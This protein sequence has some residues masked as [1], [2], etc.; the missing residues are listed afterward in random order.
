MMRI[1]V[2]SGSSFVRTTAL[3]LTVAQISIGVPAIASSEAQQ[4]TKSVESPSVSTPKDVTPNR[5]VPNVAPLSTTL[6]LPAYPTDAELSHARIFAEPL[7]PMPRPTSPQENA[8]LARAILI[9]RDAHRSE[10]V[11]PLLDFLARFPQSAWRPSLLANLGTIY[12]SNGYLARALNAWNLAWDASKVETE[13]HAHAVADFALGELLDLSAKVGKA[14]AVAQRLQEIEKRPVSGPATQRIGVAREAL[15][16]F[17][18]HHDQAVASGPA[19]L[20]GI[21]AYTAYQQHTTRGPNAVLQQYHTMPSGTSLRDLKG[22][23]QQVGLQWQMVFRPAGAELPIPSVV[24]W[25]VDHYSAIVKKDNNRYLLLDPILGG[26][27]WVSREMLDDETSGYFLAPAAAID[28]SWRRV[29]DQ[30]AANVIGH[31]APGAPDDTDPG[32]TDDDPSCGM[33]V[34]SMQMMQAS[35]RIRDTPVQCHAPIGPATRFQATYNQRSSGE[36][37]TFYYG[38]VGPKWT[39]DW[40]SWV[41][42]DPTALD[43]EADVYL[44]GG[45]REHFTDGVVHDTTPYPAH[46]RTRAVL[47]KV[48]SDPVRY[49]RRLRDGGVEVFAQSDGTITSGRRVFLTDIIDPQGL[50]LHLT[51]DSSLRLVAVTDAIG[52]VTTLSYELAS[53]P[54]K[55]TKVT[56]PF[57]RFATLTYN[58]GGQLA[59][60]TDVISLTSRFVYGPYDFVA[61]MTTPYGTT[62]F[63]HET[64]QSQ[65]DS[66][67]FLQATDPVGGTERVEFRYSTSQIAATAAAAEVPTGFSAYNHDLDHFN[68]VYWDKRAMS[69]YPGDV[70]KATITHWRQFSYYSYVPFFYWHGFSTS[71]LSS[72]KRPL[73]NRVWYAYPDDDSTGTAVGT[74]IQPTKVARVLD[75][76]SSQIWQATYND[77]GYPTTVADPVGRQTTLSYASNNIDVA[78]VRQTSSGLNDL[79]ASFTSYTSQHRPQT[80]VDAAGETWT[81]TYNSFG[82]LLTSTNPKSETTTRSYDANGYLLSIVGPVAG[83]TT[84]YAYDAYGRTHTVTESDGYVITAAYDALDRLTQITYPDATSDLTVYDRLDVTQRVDRAGRITRYFHDPL[85]R[86]AT[87]RDPLGR[88]VTQQWCACGSLDKL[89]DGNGH[90][91]SWERDIENRVTREVRADGVTATQYTYEATTSRLATVTDPKGQVATYTYAADDRVTQVAYTNAEHS[92][93]SVSFTY[94]A[95]YPRIATMTDGTGLTTYSYKSVG[96]L[97]GTQLASVDGPLGNDTITYD[98][99][100]LGRAIGRAINGT[101]LTLTLDTLGRLATETNPLG[102]FTYGYVGQTSRIASATYPNG[103]TSTYSYFDN[104]GDRRLQT[105]HHKNADQTTLSRFD[106]SYDAVSNITTWTRQAGA[107]STALALGYDAAD[108]LT[109]A[110]DQSTGT[111]PTVLQRFG[112]AYDA[113]GNRTTEEI[114]DAV[115][116]SAYDSLNR[117]TAKTV[118]GAIRV[119][120]S[121]DEQAA[122]SI[123]GK[124]ASTD[125][126]GHFSGIASVS[127]GTTSFTVTATDPSGNQST[128]TYEVDQAGTNATLT[129]DANGNLSNDGTRTFEW[130]AENQLV[131]VTLGTHRSEFTYDGLDRRARIVEKENGTTVRDA[132]LIWDRTELAEERLSTGE[133]NRFFSSGEQ[134]NGVARFLTRD[135]IGSIREVTDSMGAVI[136]R[137]EYDPYGRLTRVAGTEDSRFGYTGHMNHTPSGLALALYR[138]YDP[139]LGRWLS[140]DPSGL[141]NGTNLYAYVTNSPARLA[142]PLGLWE[143]KPKVPQPSPDMTAL[144]DYLENTTGIDLR[145]TSTTDSHSKS[146]PHSRGEAVDVSYGRKYDPEKSKEILTAAGDYGAQFAQDEYVHPSAHRNGPHI[147]IQMPPGRNGGSGDL[148][149]KPKQPKKPNGPKGN[150]GDNNCPS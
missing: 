30:E 135:H 95:A 43:V 115:T 138:A 44:R 80:T 140:D 122:V 102:T 65:T 13:P 22:L 139:T 107:T 32:P 17:Q 52:Q 20:E 147:H 125:A 150:N 100:E 87:T 131:A 35:L 70:T 99:D 5:T 47:A 111:N 90:A 137:N 149:K 85:R 148:P 145:V 83:A 121:T 60:I 91:T 98:Y 25:R 67:R 133:V 24:H 50:S 103:Q 110:V 114:D 146:D 109:S 76:G 144:L 15:I 8:A 108:Q 142:D 84:T 55:V 59:S 21:L 51:Y 71:V 40:L 79:L 141:E 73:E 57:G 134:H 113:G 120:G 3:V 97:G 49:E 132:T 101:G 29:P 118:G 62:L 7:A 26:L 129:F 16:A 130:D 119:T 72:V 39:F 41:S 9:Y 31:C 77:H 27:K 54:L 92:T 12:R 58:A 53:D 38:N 36:P 93:P 116:T 124:A 10:M 126:T 28:A 46:W 64:D 136:T 112:Y 88:V 66:F 63:S 81:A 14:D 33:P 18:Y 104:T 4:T 74:W 48:S 86:L 56:D 6:V 78:E 127:T 61:S 128:A 23:A 11:A 1:S 42:D 82:Q 45:G 19:A 75:D 143:V 34:Y 106:Y 89:I 94:D 123:Q 105:I 117:L 69:L 2:K 96:V 68:S 37:Q